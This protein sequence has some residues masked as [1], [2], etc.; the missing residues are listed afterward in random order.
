MPVGLSRTESLSGLQA[1]GHDGVRPSN[2]RTANR[3]PVLDAYYV[4]CAAAYSGAQLALASSPSTIVVAALLQQVA[5]QL[6]MAET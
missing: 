3:Q 6:H 2:L 4:S 5:D 1:S